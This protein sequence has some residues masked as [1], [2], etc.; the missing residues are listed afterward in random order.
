MEIQKYYKIVV[1]KFSIYK[2]AKLKIQLKTL[3]L[4]A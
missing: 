3:L 4:I 2:S 1:R